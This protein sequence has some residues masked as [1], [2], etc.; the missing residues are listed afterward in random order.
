MQYLIYCA[1]QKFKKN[2]WHP[3]I[4]IFVAILITPLFVTVAGTPS[5]IVFQTIVYIMFGCFSF[6]IVSGFD[7]LISSEM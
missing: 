1:K 6:G 4:D 3:V 7:M 5:D 2:N